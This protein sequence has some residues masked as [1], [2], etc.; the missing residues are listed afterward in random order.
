MPS[1]TTL[2]APAILAL[3][4]SPGE[5]VHA[6]YAID[7]D[8]RS[9]AIF[10][11][12]KGPRTIRHFR[13][14]PEPGTPSEVWRSARLR[15]VWDGDD[16]EEAAVDLPLGAFVTPPEGDR[17]GAFINRRAMPYRRS[18]RIVIEADGPVRGTFRVVADAGGIGGR[19]AEYLYAAP[20]DVPGRAAT[21][22]R[23]RHPARDRRELGADGS[24]NVPLL[25][26]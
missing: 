19:G 12:P 26:P 5:A 4:P 17:E 16:P 8:G 10:A 23:G 11:L 7:L 2:L 20:G 14:E 22:W 18:G 9:E 25:N 24:A 21:Y 6:R 13:W 3:A 15:L 1:I